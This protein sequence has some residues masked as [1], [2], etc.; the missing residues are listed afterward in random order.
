M[1]FISLIIF[2]NFW[3]WWCIRILELHSQF[4]AEMLEKY[5]LTQA[6]LLFKSWAWFICTADFWIL[7]WYDDTHMRIWHYVTQLFCLFPSFVFSLNKKAIAMKWHFDAT[8][9]LND[10]KWES[11]IWGY[12]NSV[13]F[14]SPTE[15]WKILIR[16]W[17]HLITS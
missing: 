8:S 10:S 15:W 1:W 16:K 6:V 4:H 17:D 3:K 11:L 2:L 7:L 12:P 9:L 13:N 5:V 14:L